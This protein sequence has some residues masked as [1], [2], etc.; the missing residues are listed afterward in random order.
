MMDA[1][2]QALQA[3]QAGE[4]TR[5]VV[6]CRQVLSTNPF[7][8][9]VLSLLAFT[10]L[11]LGELDQVI[12]ACRQAL[13]ISP[14]DFDAHNALGIA[15][16]R[17]KKWAEAEMSFRH[18]I[19]VSPERSDGYNNLGVTLVEQGK[20]EEAE[21]CYRGALRLNPNS[22][23]SLNNLGNA[24]RGQG[25]LADAEV[26]FQNAIRLSPNYAEAH[27]NLGL[28]LKEQ[29]RLDDAH[30]AYRRAIELRPT[31]AEAFNNLGN[32]LNA[33]QRF[34]EAEA[35]YR[36]VLQL[37]PGN[38]EAHSNLGVL[39]TDEGRL[40]EA[41]EHYAE[42]IRIDPNYASAHYNFGIHL[43]LRGDFALGWS[44]YEWR[45]K[46]R[47][48]PPYGR[49]FQQPL[50]DGSPLDGR[51]I[52][53]HTE[54]GLGDSIQFVRFASLAK[55]RGA[56]VVVECQPP[57][58]TLFSRASGVD[59]AL[60]EG[61][62]LPRFDVQA[63]LMTLPH[64]LRTSVATI[65]APVP[66][67]TADPDQVAFWRSTWAPLAGLK[68]GIVWRGNPRHK[69][70]RNR[71]VPLT[72]F[73]PLASVAG[74][75][76]VSLQKGPAREEIA[77]F[78][79]QHPLLEWDDRADRG[80]G[81]FLDTAAVVTALDLVISVDT[82]AVHLAGAL[83]VPVWCAL[84]AIPDWRWLLGRDD[85]PWYPTLRLFRQTRPGDWTGVFARMAEELHRVKAPGRITEA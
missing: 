27:H 8:T 72:A 70:D 33:Q 81:S 42:A 57:L 58:V 74:V 31:Y 25:K 23:E 47:K 7:Q 2:A 71:S 64:V 43:L 28:V 52:L 17:Q 37:N 59:H 75:H 10:H 44:E 78:K 73:A 55:S 60:P 32:V 29:G 11:A 80:D 13:Q 12:V 46:V 53:L 19:R 21:A 6:L 39:L 5:A 15:L 35:C 22:A 49:P 76:L 79:A 38:A 1:F 83:G 69:N 50:W 20:L 36:R 14:N 24:L 16:G 26:S 4:Y 45:W 77:P 51:T 40:D 65:P 9:S 34:A 67:L 68:V 82:A 41:A 85:S 3:Y 63:P 61:S 56:T 62:A 66:Y 84:P 54:Q 48:V 18:L 30:A